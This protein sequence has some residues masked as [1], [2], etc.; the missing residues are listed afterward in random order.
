MGDAIFR[1]KDAEDLQIDDPDC[2]ARR[3]SWVVDVAHAM[4]D[5]GA[6]SSSSRR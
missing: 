1:T 2:R 5:A 6:Q 4:D 3:P